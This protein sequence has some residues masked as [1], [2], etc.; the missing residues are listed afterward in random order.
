VASP[1]SSPNHAVEDAGPNAPTVE[2]M[3]YQ[4]GGPHLI[5]ADD[6]RTEFS[7]IEVASVARG[8]RS[9]LV[10][11]GLSVAGRSASRTGDPLNH[12]RS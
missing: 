1:C 9:V 11:G 5:R 12:G 3:D 4:D 8:I 2:T 7:P 10:L 6:D